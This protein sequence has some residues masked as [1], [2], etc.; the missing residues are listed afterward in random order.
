MAQF[1]PI[2]GDIQEVKP[3][4]GTKFGLQEAQ[5]IIGGY[6]QLIPESDWGMSR[7]IRIL[8]DEEGTL[9][10]LQ[11]NERATTILHTAMAEK[12]HVSVAQLPQLVGR[13]L[14]YLPRIVGPALVL[15]KAEKF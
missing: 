5:T 15:D 1:I 14:R 11:F 8:C 4:N 12:L 10:K 6:L 9:K 13:R 2:A 3:K 7:F